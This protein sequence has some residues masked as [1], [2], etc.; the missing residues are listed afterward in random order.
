MPYGGVLKEMIYVPGKLFSVNTVTAQQVPALF[1]FSG[2]HGDYH[3]PSDTWDKIDPAAYA[4]LIRV[5]AATAIRSSVTRTRCSRTHAK[6]RSR[7]AM[8]PTP[9]AW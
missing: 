7:S 1:F 2:L 8:P 5:V 3:K 6:R 4:A 9:M